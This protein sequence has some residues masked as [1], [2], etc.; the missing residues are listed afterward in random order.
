MIADAEGDKPQTTVFTCQR[1]FSKKEDDM[2]TKRELFADIDVEKAAAKAEKLA[3][4]AEKVRPCSGCV[5]MLLGCSPA[6]RVLPVL[7]VTWSRPGRRRRI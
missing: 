7:G 5:P 4:K 1:W 6:T 2:Q 3:V